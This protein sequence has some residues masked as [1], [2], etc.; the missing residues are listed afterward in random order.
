MVSAHRATQ[1]VVCPFLPSCEAV[2]SD[3]DYCCPAGQEGRR[4]KE[5]LA[6][7]DRRRLGGDGGKGLIIDL[8]ETLD[9]FSAV[10]K[11]FNKMILNSAF[12][13]PS[14]S[15]GSWLWGCCKTATSFK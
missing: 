1:K 5:L 3:T 13:K 2:V 10:S 4:E 8:T 12:M 11:A 14:Y 15:P 6:V 9:S 7:Q